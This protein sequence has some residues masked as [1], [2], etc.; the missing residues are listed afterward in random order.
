MPEVGSLRISIV[1]AKTEAPFE[2]LN[3]IINERDGTAECYVESQRGSQ[4]KVVIDL[5]PRPVPKTASYSAEFCVDGESVNGLY[6][7]DVGY[8]TLIH[9]AERVG[10]LVGTN[11][12]APFIF[13]DT[14]FTGGNRLSAQSC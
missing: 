2:E 4:F 11:Q 7:G 9:K 13:G 10:M 1:D 8:K 3:P 6:F 14:Q 5:D 12:V